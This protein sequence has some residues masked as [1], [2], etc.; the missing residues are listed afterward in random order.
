MAGAGAASGE[1]DEDAADSRAGLEAPR[2]GLER[3]QAQLLFD[4][5]LA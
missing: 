3:G 1:A 2:F 4:Q 5:L